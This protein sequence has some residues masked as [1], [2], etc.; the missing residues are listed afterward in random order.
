MRAPATAG[1]SY[2]RDVPS[3]RAYDVPRG[4]EA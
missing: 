2:G 1:T 4:A 3:C